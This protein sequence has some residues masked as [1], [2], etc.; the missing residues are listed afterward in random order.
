MTIQPIGRDDGGG[1]RPRDLYALFPLRVTAPRHPLADGH[2][3]VPIEVFEVPP[4]LIDVIRTLPIRSNAVAPLR[5]PVELDRPV[6]GE[7]SRR[8]ATEPR[9][10]TRVD[11]RA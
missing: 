4:E 3:R 2:G 5:P 7:P 8:G 9:R 11:L 10:G 6:P 1:A